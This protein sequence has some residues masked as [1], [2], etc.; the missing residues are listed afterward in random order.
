M[1]V[2]PFLS[3]FD[4]WN[5]QLGTCQAKRQFSTTTTTTTTTLRRNVAECP[6]PSPHTHAPPNRCHDES[7]RAQR[8]IRGHQV[9]PVLVVPSLG[10]DLR[11]WRRRAKPSP[12][13]EIASQRRHNTKT[14]RSV[15]EHHSNQPKL[16][17]CGRGASRAQEG[18]F[19]RWKVELTSCPTASHLK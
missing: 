1:T 18:A 12:A 14:W 4:S 7:Q 6:P 8:A 5:L 16:R 15:R 9:P 17:G 13:V 10:G 11:G 19:V 2:A 3:Y